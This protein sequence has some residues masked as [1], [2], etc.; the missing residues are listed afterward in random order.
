MRR[1]VSFQIYVAV[2]TLSF[3]IPSFHRLENRK[4]GIWNLVLITQLKQYVKLCKIIV[5]GQLAHLS[6]CL[7]Q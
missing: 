2:G 5:R 1:T 4:S 3:P 7:I 6:I